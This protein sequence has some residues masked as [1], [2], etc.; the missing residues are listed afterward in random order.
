VDHSSSNQVPRK[1]PRNHLVEDHCD[2]LRLRTRGDA[3]RGFASGS[4]LVFGGVG[5]P[6]LAQ[7]GLRVLVKI[8]AKCK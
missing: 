5:E 1:T 7:R 2:G 8:V 3:P 6:A 4:E